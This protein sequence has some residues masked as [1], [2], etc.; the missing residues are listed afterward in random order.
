MFHST[1]NQNSFFTKHIVLI[2]DENKSVII[3]EISVPFDVFIGQCFQSKFDKYF[4]LCCE[5][6]ELGYHTEIVVLILG[7]LGH[8]HKKFVSGLMKNNIT[9]TE[10]KF[11][12]NFCSVSAMMGSFFAW[13]QRCRLNP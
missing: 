2:D 13:K 11:I 4:P 6:N 3:T 9:K 7:S 5:I 10:A 1:Q 8:V 12:T